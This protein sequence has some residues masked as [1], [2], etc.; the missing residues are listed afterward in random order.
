MDLELPTNINVEP[1]PDDTDDRVFRA[2]Q[3]GKPALETAYRYFHGKF[4]N[5]DEKT[6]LIFWMGHAFEAWLKDYIERSDWVLLDTQTPHEWNG[7]DGSSDFIVR[8]TEGLKFIID[9]KAVNGRCFNKYKRYG[10]L[11]DRG[12]ATQLSIYSASSGLPACIVMMNKENGDVSYAW[13]REKEQKEECLDRAKYI[14]EKIIQSNSF[15][16]CFAYFRPPEPRVEMYQKEPTGRLLPPDCY[17]RHPLRDILYETYTDTNNRGEEKVYVSDYKY[18][19]QY[20]QYKPDIN[21]LIS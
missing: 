17:V 15:E 19:E 5:P 1:R 4:N 6:K 13:L 21:D 9:A 12:Y 7:I 16:E 18:P 20:K 2:S 10:L 11:D 8:D 14:R 3:M